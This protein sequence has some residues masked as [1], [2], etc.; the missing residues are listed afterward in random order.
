MSS[1]HWVAQSQRQVVG[2]DSTGECN[3]LGVA[4]AASSFISFVSAFRTI[5]QRLTAKEPS[6]LHEPHEA[7]LRRIDDVHRH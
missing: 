3:T 5:R 6:V 7:L 2:A 4:K 1:S